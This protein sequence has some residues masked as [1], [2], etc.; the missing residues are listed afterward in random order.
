MSRHSTSKPEYM[1]KYITSK[2]ECQKI[3][4]QNQYICQTY[5]FKTKVSKHIT[6]K[7][8]YMSNIL[9]QN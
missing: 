3:S 1:P 6:S 4:P 9:L 8:K 7:L 2:L 5:Y